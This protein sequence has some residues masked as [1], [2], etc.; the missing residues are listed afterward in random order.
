MPATLALEEVDFSRPTA[1]VFGNERLGVSA[2]ML[3]HCD[4]AF[5]IPL[6][7]L[8][9]SLNVSVAA[10]IAMHYGRVQRVDALQRLGGDGLNAHGGDLPTDAVD[11]LCADYA[12]RGRNHAK[13]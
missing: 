6:H 11:E 10:A 8:T 5:H 7:G 9:E 12:Q 2:E 13:A 1:L 4:G 3:A